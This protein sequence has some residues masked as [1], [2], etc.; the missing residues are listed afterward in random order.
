MSNTQIRKKIYLGDSVYASFDGY[1]IVLTTE[2][3]RGP[4]NTIALEDLVFNS[5]ILFAESCWQRR[6]R[7]DPDV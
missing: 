6:L 1:H 4:T 3:G 7:Y 2:N 5:L